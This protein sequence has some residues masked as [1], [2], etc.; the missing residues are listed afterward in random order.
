MSHLR[1]DQKARSE[2][3]HS[4]ECSSRA[5]RVYSGD[6]SERVKGPFAANLFDARRELLFTPGPTS[7][8]SPAAI[9]AEDRVK[10]GGKGREREMQ[11]YC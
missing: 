9:A 10:I 7:I 8:S 5:V 4:S 3:R 2:K 6:N 11:F 1:P